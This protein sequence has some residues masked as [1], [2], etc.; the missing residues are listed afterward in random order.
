[1]SPANNE[2]IENIEVTKPDNKIVWGREIKQ[3]NRVGMC[4]GHGVCERHCESKGSIISFY[5]VQHVPHH[6][7]LI[8]N[9]LQAMLTHHTHSMGLPRPIL[10]DRTR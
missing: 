3:D 6:L 7:N 4:Q 2:I 9:V 8:I 1:M 5:R 10:K